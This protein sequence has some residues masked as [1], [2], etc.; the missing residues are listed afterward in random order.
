MLSKLS[1]NSIGVIINMILLNVYI[2]ANENVERNK[3]MLTQIQKLRNVFERFSQEISITWISNQDFFSEKQLSATELIKTQFIRLGHDLKYF[4]YRKFSTLK[5][6][7]Y[8]II[9][10]FTHTSIWMS[11]S[12]LRRFKRF[13]KVQKIVNYKHD[14]AIRMSANSSKEFFLVFEDDAIIQDFDIFASEILNLMTQKNDIFVNLANVI[15]IH[16]LCL[17]KLVTIKTES[18]VWFGNPVTNGL[19]AYFFNRSFATKLLNKRLQSELFEY[20]PCDYAFNELFMKLKYEDSK[21]YSKLYIN[22]PVRHGSEDTFS[23]TSV[24]SIF[25]NKPIK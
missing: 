15:H 18:E 12:T 19:C 11:R 22:P 25:F 6:F 5:I 3:M 4:R 10:F 13:V 8:F 17:D 24:S 2:I 16:D 23:D 14:L 20:L 21:I 9:N 1:D 7:Y